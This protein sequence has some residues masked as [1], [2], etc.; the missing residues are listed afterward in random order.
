MNATLPPVTKRE[1]IT[2]LVRL[3]KSQHTI[4]SRRG[5]TGE[6]SCKRLRVLNAV[7]DCLRA[8]PEP[9]KRNG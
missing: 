4:A 6:Q 9:G 7:V 2:E 1:M 3:M 8:L 5:M